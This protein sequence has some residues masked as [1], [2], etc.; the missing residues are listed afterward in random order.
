MFDPANPLNEGAK[1]RIVTL[2]DSAE[3]RVD[4]DEMTAVSTREQLTI[5]LLGS[6]FSDSIFEGLDEKGQEEFVAYFLSNRNS[7]HQV[8]VR[9]LKRIAGMTE[10]M[11]PAATSRARTRYITTAEKM[12]T[13]Y[14]N[15]TELE[16]TVDKTRQE[17]FI[18]DVQE[19]FQT[20][21]ASVA[22]HLKGLAIGVVGSG[23]GREAV[24]RAAFVPDKYRALRMVSYGA[25]LV[26]F[27]GFVTKGI[28]LPLLTAG[29]LRGAV[30]NTLKFVPG[31]GNLGVTM[32]IAIAV[33]SFILMMAF[34]ATYLKRIAQRNVPQQMI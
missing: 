34:K 15:S 9:L 13:D 14:M 12:K 22:A 16:K 4:G 19:R 29:G 7:D 32:L 11:L 31:V 24:E 18:R 10:A 20:E 2:F 33:T 30:I 28:L 27:Y 6:M 8:T 26:A 1:K 5:L 3:Y 25:L 23:E 21:E 17:D